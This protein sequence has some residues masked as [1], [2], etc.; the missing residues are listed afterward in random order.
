[1]TWA[2]FN[3]PDLINE[4]GE[5]SFYSYDF[6]NIK[7]LIS[8]VL[9]FGAGFG[10]MVI[11]GMGA[12]ELLYWIPYLSGPDSDGDWNSTRRVFSFLIGLFLGNPV[13]SQL[14]LQAR[15]NYISSFGLH[16]L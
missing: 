12:Y 8:K 5:Y 7:Y 13:H 10:F 9:L 4:K 1:M 14:S 11:I 16:P 2:I 6:S 15:N 3:R